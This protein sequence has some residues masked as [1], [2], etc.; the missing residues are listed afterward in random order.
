MELFCFWQEGTVL[1][2]REATPILIAVAYVIDAVLELE[3]DDLDNICHCNEPQLKTLSKIVSI[4]KGSY[5]QLKN[6]Q[7]QAY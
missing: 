6:Q 5:F 2:E 7:Q 3:N 1:Y 4:L